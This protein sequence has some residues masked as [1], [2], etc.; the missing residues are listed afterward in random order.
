M[1]W[2]GNKQFEWEAQE[3]AFCPTL[4]SCMQRSAGLV[5]CVS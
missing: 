5:H 4:F 1:Q 2:K 3:G